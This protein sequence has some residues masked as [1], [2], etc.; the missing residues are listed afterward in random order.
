VNPTATIVPRPEARA[1]Q[2]DDLT[3]VEE[4]ARGK[5]AELEEQRKR[6]VIAALSDPKAKERLREN[7]IAQ[8]DEENRIEGVRLTRRRRQQERLAADQRA[9]AERKA[10]Y[11]T[12]AR[13]ARDEKRQVAVEVDKTASI[14]GQLLARFAALHEDEDEALVAAGDRPWG[15]GLDSRAQMLGA[16]RLGLLEANGPDLLSPRALRAAE[17]QPAAPLVNSVPL[18]Q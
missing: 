11:R 2:R 18:Q 3:P 5:L 9:E 6:L 8:S 16:M 10:G 4:A 1:E 15:Q 14:F 13:R 17:G 12:A 7:R